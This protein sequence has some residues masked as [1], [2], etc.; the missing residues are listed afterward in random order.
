MSDLYIAAAGAGK[1]TFLVKK[2]LQQTNKKILITTFTDSNEQGIREKFYQIHGCI[3][4]NVSIVPWYTFLIRHG[5]RPYQ[6]YIT[7]KTVKGIHM[8]NAEIPALRYARDDE[9]RNYI[10]KGGRVYSDKISK[11]AY[12]LNE[13]S[14]G[15]VIDRFKN[16]FSDIYIDEVQ[17]LA[18]HDFEIIK[19]LCEAGVNLTLVGDVR[20]TTYKTHYEAKN[21]KYS[22]GGIEEYCK[23]KIK[24][25][26]I[27]T[28]SLNTT[29]RNNPEICA[30][31]NTLYPNMIGCSSDMNEKTG[32][33][34][35]FWVSDKDVDAYLE[36]F[37]PMQLRSDVR[38]R[39]NEEYGVLTFGNSKGLG[40]D[41]VLIYP[42]KPML[43]WI[44]GKGTLK[45]ESRCKAY[46]AVTRAKYSVAFVYST[47]NPPPNVMVK[48]WTPEQ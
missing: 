42:T 33:D 41:R 43:E 5:I 3:P 13:M 27:D 25:V 30:F 47:K 23:D 24:S 11:L 35:L 38:K 19:L 48:M 44:A 45:D 37:S 17:D 16:I 36:A 9:E 18:G 1:T 46:V 21:K 15:C 8:V 34:G 10:T 14:K 26:N 29:H 4:Q 40:F 39:V 22:K 31:A 32:H 2:A 6:S 12:K 20:Q 7:D 28:V